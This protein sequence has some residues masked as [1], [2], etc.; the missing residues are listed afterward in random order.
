ML[1][2]V[3]RSF[4]FLTLLVGTVSP[5]FA[6]EARLLLADGS[7]AA[8]YIV[9][10]VGRPISVPTAADGSFRLEPSPPLPFQVVAR[11]P[12][13]W[14]A[15]AVVVESL[16][17][18]GPVE[19]R[20]APA[21]RDSVT[22]VS[23]VAPGLDLLPGAAAT[24]VSVEALEQRPPQRLFQALEAVAGA[25]K[26]GEGADSVPAL[27][28][29]GRGR[30][31]ILIDGARVT[32][33]RRAGPSATFVDPGSL[34][35]VEV[36]R[37]PGSVVY[38]SDAFGGV[39]N[40]VTR[41][42]EIDGTALRWSVDGATGGQPL[43]AGF[44]AGSFRVGAGSLWVEAHG[45]D[46]DDGEA[47]GGKE[48]FNSGFSSLGGA[49][50]Y[51]VPAGP[52]R[53]R[54]SL[55]VERV[56]DLGKAAIDAR[57]IR[58]FY[59]LEDSDRLQV[60]WLGATGSWDELEAALYYG[61]YHVILD[62]DRA[63]TATSNRR[64]DSSDTDS[65]DASLR[66][67]G[68]RELGGGRLQLGLDVYGRFDL[69]S[70]TGRTTFAEDGETVT[71]VTEQVSIEK[72]SQWTGGLFAVWSRPLGER[73]SLGLGA[74]GDRIE[75]ENRGGYFGDRKESASP[76]SGNLALTVTPAAGWSV[77]AQ[78]ARGF[79]SPTL[80]DRYFR[81]PS[82][83]GFV[84]GN[85]DLDPESALQ[86]DLAVRHGRAG[87]SLALYAYRYEIDD[88]IERYREGDDFFFRNRGEARVEGIEIEA[89][90]ALSAEW[91]LEAGAAWTRS[92][93]GDGEPIDDAPAPNGFVGLRWSGERF[94]GW[95]RGTVF[96]DKDDPG[97]TEVERPGYELLDLGGGYRLSD[98]FE[99]RLTVRNA[100]DLRYFASPDESAD[101]SPG[102]T[103]GLGF[104][105]RF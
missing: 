84:T 52:G 66:W 12:D 77:T 31:L 49:A 39:L 37:G 7:A 28:G 56:D 103:I 47:G 88:L 3:R 35:A 91:D 53:L 76:L 58:G 15:P 98:A 41:D 6:I 61:R 2:F 89:Q 22:V 83:R 24:V 25:S 81:G 94:Y 62:R 60:S 80:S 74:R 14:L 20:L 99:V 1:P 16:P 75:T 55:M 79:R 68:A 23:G 71:G 40:A 46:A 64:I 82:G 70:I 105:G 42:P 32:A 30:T 18:S 67:V 95:L 97:P 10:V 72:A 93:A 48:I 38:G 11:A 63:P 5:L 85:P 34:A 21:V 33:E 8:G 73:V 101:R 26:L 51:L 86:W 4:V 9:S 29:L 27:R 59:P 92:R 36:V 13:G 54:A 100:T 78:V 43:I 17:E 44:L 45:A 102:R 65:D 19:V 96:L 90:S 69:S 104:S 57:E 87:R 50:R